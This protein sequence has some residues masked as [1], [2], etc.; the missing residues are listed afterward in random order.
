MQR[1]YVC[2]WECS[3]HM[4]LIGS[5]ANICL[6]FGVQRTYVCNL[7]RSEHMFGIWS[8]ANI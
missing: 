3:E 6:Q 8:E 7:E 4:F 2:N 5:A 1:T